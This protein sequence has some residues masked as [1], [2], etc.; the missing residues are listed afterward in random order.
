M[1]D[2]ASH[3]AVAKPRQ[4]GGDHGPCVLVAADWAAGPQAREAVS[5]DRQQDRPR[6]AILVANQT[7]QHLQDTYCSAI[8][9]LMLCETSVCFFVV[10]NKKR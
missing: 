8:G 5:S 9:H 1:V 3:V 7:Q 2:P 6:K 10:H 4:V